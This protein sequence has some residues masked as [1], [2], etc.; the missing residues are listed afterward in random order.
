MGAPGL[1]K[2]CRIIVVSSLLLLWSVSKFKINIR[3][4]DT[5]WGRKVGNTLSAA[6]LEVVSKIFIRR[7]RENSTVLNAFK[8]LI[9][10]YMYTIIMPHIVTYTQHNIHFVQS[11]QVQGVH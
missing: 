6:I 7:R 5:V 1:G 10:K 2:A 9:W 8:S 11:V 4:F 3:K